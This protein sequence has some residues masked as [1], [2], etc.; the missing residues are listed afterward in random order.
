M[1]DKREVRVWV[2]AALILLLPVLVLGSRLYPY[3]FGE[4][5]SWYGIAALCLVSILA[6]LWLTAPTF[7]R[8]ADGEQS[9][10]R[11]LW[12]VAG[13]IAGG[14]LVVLMAGILVLA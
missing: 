5:L 11:T 8:S 4:G 3:L 7:T 12:S 1:E 13:V 2:V 6:L 14:L 10:S 9:Q